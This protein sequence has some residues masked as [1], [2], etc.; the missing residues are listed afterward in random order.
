MKPMNFPGRKLARQIA[1]AKR[2]GEPLPRMTADRARGI[3]TKKRRDGSA[4]LR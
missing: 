4:K 1:A 2:N 3:R